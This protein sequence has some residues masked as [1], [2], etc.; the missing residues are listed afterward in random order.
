M[1]TIKCQLLTVMSFFFLLVIGNTRSTNAQFKPTEPTKNV[2]K[3]NFGPIEHQKYEFGFEKALSSTV[4]LELDV[5]YMGGK[6]DDLPTEGRRIYTEDY[7][8]FFFFLS[9]NYPPSESPEIYVSNER[10]GLA[11]E[12]GP[13]IYPFSGVF[14]TDKANRL[15]KRSTTDPRKQTRLKKRIM[16]LRTPIYNKGFYFKPE[17]IMSAYNV[18]HYYVNRRVD[19]ELET[20]H[21]FFL[22][23]E[24]SFTVDE[25][26]R[27]EDVAIATF[28]GKVNIGYQFAIADRINF[29]FFAGVGKQWVSEKK[30]EEYRYRGGDGMYE[31]DSFIL[32]D[33]DYYVFG[34]NLL[35]GGMKVGVRF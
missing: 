13:R 1:K 7:T 9:D 26:V 28:G 18:D 15:A 17:L 12:F 2:L 16:R 19:S 4:S 11:L 10:R 33:M 34:P 6:D 27:R 32:P 31:D 35:S 22:G 29:D 30:N 5:A 20:L 25:T 23:G 21:P 8:V 14:R 24:G 3:Y